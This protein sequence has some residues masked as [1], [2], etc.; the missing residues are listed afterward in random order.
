MAKQATGRKQETGRQLVK[1]IVDGDERGFIDLYERYQGRVR[2]FALR[3]WAW[4]APSAEALRALDGLS[5]IL[6]GVVVIGLMAALGPA[7]RQTP[8]LVLGWTAVVFA[9]NFG[10]QGAAFMLLRNKPGAVPR[11]IIAG[12]R[13]V[14]LYL[15]ALPPELSAPL[16]IFIGCYQL[17]MFL[18]PILMAPLYRRA[19]A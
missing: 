9:A 11:S 8:W 19:A 15:I 16:L 5:A 2:A 12:N 18:T 6:L 10:L 14:A 7:L 13:N 1:R 3:R 4:P 17:P